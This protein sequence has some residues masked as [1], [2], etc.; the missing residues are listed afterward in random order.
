MFGLDD[1][2]SIEQVKQIAE[3][4]TNDILGRE[5]ELFDKRMPVCKACPLYKED[6]DQCDGSKCINPR[7]GEI[8]SYPMTEYICGCNCIMSKKTRV[9]NAHCVLNKW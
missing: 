9:K 5:Q 3:G 8:V 7:T 1:I 4:W 2:H 6:T